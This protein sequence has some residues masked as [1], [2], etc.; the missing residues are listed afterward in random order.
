MIICRHWHSLPFI[1]HFSCSINWNWQKHFGWLMTANVQLHLIILN[2]GLCKFLHGRLTVMHSSHIAS[3]CCEYHGH[4]GSISTAIGLNF[5]IELCNFTAF[6][7]VITAARQ[8]LTS[9]TVNTWQIK[10]WV[11]FLVF[12]HF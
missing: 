4:T 2:F 7:K 5:R 11:M 10:L 12:L 6:W 8:A 9:F 1:V 3:I